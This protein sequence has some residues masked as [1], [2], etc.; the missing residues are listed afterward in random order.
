MYIRILTGLNFFLDATA[1]SL[2][3]IVMV[4]IDLLPFVLDASTPDGCKLNKAAHA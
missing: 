4:L 2:L 3:K 1:E